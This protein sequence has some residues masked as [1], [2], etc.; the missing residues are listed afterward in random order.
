MIGMDEKEFEEYAKSRYH[1][2]IDYY[3]KAAISNHRAY[4]ILQFV[5]IVLSAV[6]PVLIVIGGE[7]ERW[8]A[9]LV[10]AVVAVTASTL[11][12]FKFQENWI[13]YRTT[14]ETLR[15][16][17]YYY[18]A[19]IHDYESADDPEAIF[20]DRVETLISREN[21]LWLISQKREEISKKKVASLT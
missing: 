4:A 18:Q 14:C 15:K 21:T 11:K 10:S 12:I 1:P 16:E 13:S 20:V 7:P 8:L 2:Q 19:R 3:N 5:L 17:F 6:V 9:V